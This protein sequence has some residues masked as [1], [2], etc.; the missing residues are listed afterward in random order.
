MKLFLRLLHGREMPRLPAGR[1]A[2]SHPLSNQILKVEGSIQFNS[3]HLYITCA[4]HNSGRCHLEHSFYYDP[5][6][7]DYHRLQPCSDCGVVWKLQRVPLRALGG[8]GLDIATWSV[9]AGCLPTY[10]RNILYTLAGSSRIQRLL[11]AKGNWEIIQPSHSEVFGSW[12]S[13]W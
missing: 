10:T 7:P 1:T 8:A 11:Y 13:S 9:G 12:M 5:L 6:A 4:Q 3:I 2:Y